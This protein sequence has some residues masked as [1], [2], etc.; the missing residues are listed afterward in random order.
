VRKRLEYQ[1]LLTIT[2]VI[3]VEHMHFIT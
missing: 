3:M 2:L 1:A